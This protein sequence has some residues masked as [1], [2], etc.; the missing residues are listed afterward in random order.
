MRLL[1]ILALRRVNLNFQRTMMKEFGERL[2]I[3][4]GNRSARVRKSDLSCGAVLHP[5]LLASESDFLAPF[6]AEDSTRS[7]EAT[8]VLLVCSLSS[9]DRQQRHHAYTSR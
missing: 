7:V 1:Q 5:A 9:S 4:S 8:A 6:L 3:L 2:A